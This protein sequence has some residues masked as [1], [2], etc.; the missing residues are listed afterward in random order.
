MDDITDR[1]ANVQMEQYRFI[2]IPYGFLLAGP[3]M[4]EDYLTRMCK[5]LTNIVKTE[6]PGGIERF[7]L[8]DWKQI[9][10]IYPGPLVSQ[11]GRNYTFERY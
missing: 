11:Y 3:I 5:D 9:I 4:Y 1:L 2:D 8:T 6:L 10:T 7:D